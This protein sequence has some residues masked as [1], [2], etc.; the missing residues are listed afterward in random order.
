MHVHWILI[1]KYYYN[2]CGSMSFLHTM[3]HL[4]MSNLGSVLFF[5]LF[6]PSYLSFTLYFSFLTLQVLSF[7]LRHTPKNLFYPPPPSTFSSLFL[8]LLSLPLLLPE[9]EPGCP[10]PLALIASFQSAWMTLRYLLQPGLLRKFLLCSA[11]APPAK[12]QPDRKR[13]WA[14]ELAM[15]REEDSR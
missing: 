6:F 8:S 10:V 3:W 2:L 9:G 12:S 11:P 15:W 1:L 4:C 5:S 7:S 14:G 13:W